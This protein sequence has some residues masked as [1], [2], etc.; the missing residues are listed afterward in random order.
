MVI[1]G[2]AVVTFFKKQFR[3]FWPKNEVAEKCN[4][5]LENAESGQGK[6][7]FCSKMVDFYEN[8]GTFLG[9]SIDDNFKGPAGIEI[10]A[11]KRVQKLRKP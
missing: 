3:K 6:C 2:D 7:H 9:I 10:I 4:K 8:Y 5:K 11:P 1:S